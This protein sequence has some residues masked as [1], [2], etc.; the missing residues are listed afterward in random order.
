MIDHLITHRP[1]M[2]NPIHFDSLQNEWVVNGLPEAEAILA[3]NC[4]PNTVA[5][6]SNCKRASFFLAAELLPSARHKIVKAAFA[7]ALQRTN[8]ERWSAQIFKPLAQ[9]LIPTAVSRGT[10]LNITVEV[11]SQYTRESLFGII[12]IPSELGWE[13]CATYAVAL[14]L[15][16]ENIDSPEGKAALYLTCGLLRNSFLQVEAKSP[17]VIIGGVRSLGITDENELITLLLPFLEMITANRQIEL[18]LKSL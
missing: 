13:L 14:R 8:V 7:H 1:N 2:L 9:R 3:S 15:L 6:G 10:K 18:P 4:E 16:H 11:L 17:N 5:G 12:G